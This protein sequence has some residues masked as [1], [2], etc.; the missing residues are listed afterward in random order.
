MI[1]VVA[2]LSS[3]M[4]DVCCL[5]VGHRDNVSCLD[6]TTN[7]QT[8]LQFYGTTDVVPQTSQKS[9]K[10]KHLGVQSFQ[11]G[12][13][14]SH[15]RS[16]C[17]LMCHRLS[18][19]SVPQRPIFYELETRLRGMRLLGMSRRGESVESEFQLSKDKV[20]FLIT[21]NKKR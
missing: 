17:V 10:F 19:R 12:S 6:I 9:Q 2:V 11:N 21:K 8:K 15:T 4:S 16:C 20:V 18:R 13:N 14:T 1:V 5:L 3:I 7:F